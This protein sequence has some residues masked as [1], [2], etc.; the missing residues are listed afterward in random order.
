MTNKFFVSLFPVKYKL[1]EK[2]T[3][4][5]VAYTPATFH[6]QAGIVPFVIGPEYGKCGLTKIGIYC[7]TKGTV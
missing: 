2:K 6:W 7:K 3:S 1:P 4:D 5:A